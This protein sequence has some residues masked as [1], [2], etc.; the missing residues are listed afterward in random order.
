MIIFGYGKLGSSVATS[1]SELANKELFC[2]TKSDFPSLKSIEDAEDKMP[3]FSLNINSDSIVYFICS[4]EEKIA[5]GIL[6]TLEKIKE[7]K[8]KIIYI[9]RDQ[10]FLSEEVEKQQK[11]VGKILQNYARSGLFE[12]ICLIDEKT[13]KQSFLPD[14]PL[15]KYDKVFSQTLAK[16]I[17][18]VNWL[19]NEESFYSD[20]EPP[21]E[22]CRINTLG[23]FAE[24]EE[25]LIFSLDNTRQKNVY[26][27]CTKKT[28]AED[29]NFME[30]VK[31][32]LK[33]LKKKEEKVE[34]KIVKTDYEQDFIY[35]L[36]HTNFV[37]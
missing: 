26:F 11:T 17:N 21:N 16:M 24:S 28:L 15:L 6:R 20:I 19:K 2:L 25:K 34:Y 7:A 13:F 36:Y 14:V 35:L 31:E 10:D 33:F 23:V 5:G 32:T 3:N 29:I 27:G 1:L 9:T 18:M 12:D 37:Q 30:K 8:I 22:A 4:G